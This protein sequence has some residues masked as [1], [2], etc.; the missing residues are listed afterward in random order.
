MLSIFAK[1][2]LALARALDEEDG[3]GLTEYTLIIVLIALVA[4]VALTLLGGKVSDQL[5]TV[6]RSL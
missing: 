6:A 5:S 4:L 2:Q 1:A 3:Q